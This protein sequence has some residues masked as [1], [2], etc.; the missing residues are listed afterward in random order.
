MIYKTLYKKAGN[1]SRKPKQETS[2]KKF[3]I[4]GKLSGLFLPL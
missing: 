4:K 1:H 2:T 3:T